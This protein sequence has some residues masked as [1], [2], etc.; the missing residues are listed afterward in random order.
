[1]EIDHL[2]GKLV[3]YRMGNYVGRGELDKMGDMYIIDNHFFKIG[4]F[5]D[6]TCIDELH[7][8]WF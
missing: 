7:T 2:L 8:F 5:R 6:V 1:M 4:D 3:E